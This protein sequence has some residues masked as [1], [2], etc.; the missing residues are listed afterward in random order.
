MAFV[1]L[2]KTHGTGGQGTVPHAIAA[3]PDW[4][5]EDAANKITNFH[6]FFWIIV[7]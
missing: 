4:A 1:Q 3:A 2:V 7:F 5:R 6:K